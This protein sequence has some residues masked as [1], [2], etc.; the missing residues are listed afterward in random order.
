MTYSGFS[1]HVAG[2]LFILLMLFGCAE[3]PITGVA[4]QPQ[5]IPTDQMSFVQWTPEMANMIQL[6]LASHGRGNGYDSEEIDEDGG[7]V[8]G[9]RTFG[10]MVDIPEGAVTEET[11]FSVEVL[12]VDHHEQCGAGVEFLPSTNFEAPVEITLSFEYLDLEDE[13]IEDLY[14]YFSQDGDFWFPLDGFEIDEDEETIIFQIDHFTIF[15][16]EF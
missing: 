5:G 12:C 16:W 1:K 14:I 6:S 13:E 9:H 7:I 2:S 3:N 10:N 15:A 11:E 8:G 4:P